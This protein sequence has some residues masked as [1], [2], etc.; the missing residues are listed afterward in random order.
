MPK[1][2]SAILGLYIRPTRDANYF[3]IHASAVWVGLTPQDMQDID[4]GA[5]LRA[6]VAND[7]IRNVCDDDA[8]YLRGLRLG[9]LTVTSQGD[10][11]SAN[12]RLYAWGVEYRN[13]FSV[14]RQSAEGMAK[15]LAAIER[16]MEAIAVKYGQPATF[17]A[18]LLRMADAIG[19]TRIVIPAGE[20]RSSYDDRQHRVLS[21]DDGAYAVDRLVANWVAETRSASV[22]AS[23]AN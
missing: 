14:D 2:T 9:S 1:K 16:R 5:G 12:R 7:R 3:H 19:A 22:S 21:L 18:Y 8:L 10:S 17:G 6:P 13:V 23:E 20:I 4:N 11:D 15:T